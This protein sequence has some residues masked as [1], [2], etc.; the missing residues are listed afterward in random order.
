MTTPPNPA[1][2]QY[3]NN[4]SGDSTQLQSEFQPR[5]AT[6]QEP[7]HKLWEGGYSPKA[8]YGTWLTLGIITVGTIL[9]LILLPTFGVMP[10]GN[11][12]VWLIALG[13]IAALWILGAFMFYY[14]RWSMY[15]EL[16]TQRFIHTQGILTRTT[17][18][19][20]VIDIDDV[21]YTQGVVQRILGVG[22]IRL[23]SKDQSHPSLNL[24]GIDQ[25]ARVSGMID[26]VR[27]KERR[28]RSLHI[29]A[30]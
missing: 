30:T 19:V 3:P 24:L 8:M 13:V 25:V 20:D 6:V 9:A 29:D 10:E 28:K 2:S 21:S 22:T 7:E 27:R 23:M 26:D 14:R 5:V 18:R 17:D 4:A 16:T 12:M 1:E 15:Y 11:Q